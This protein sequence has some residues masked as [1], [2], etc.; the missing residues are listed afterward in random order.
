MEFRLFG[1]TG[2]TVPVIGMGT[3]QTFDVRGETAE[4]N[5]RMIVEAAI[6]AG[7]N[8]FDSSP[9]YGEAERVLGKA[10]VGR[11]DDVFVATK[12][13]T[14]SA[15]QGRAQMEAAFRFFG[16]RVD[17]YQIHNLLAW[18]THLPVLESLRDEGRIRA[19]GATHYSASAFGEL[20]RVMQTGRITAIQIPYNPLER[21]VEKEILPLAADL[22]LGVIIM[23][24][25]SGGSLMRKAPSAAELAPLKPFGITTWAQALLKWGLSDPRCHIAIPA[26]SHVSRMIENATITPQWFGEEERKWVERLALR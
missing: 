4:H 18:Q 3:W 20:K 23:R 24:P 2:L 10:L 14:Q 5:A 13:W 19:I 12:V 6:Q 11:R 15:S 21:D 7:A 22:N 17:L 25:L 8:F 9:M 26:T 16:G 1:Q